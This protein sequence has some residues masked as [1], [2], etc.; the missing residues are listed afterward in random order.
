MINSTMKYGTFKLISGE[1]I[2][3]EYYVDDDNHIVLN[4]PVQIHRTITAAGPML[5]V[6]H[7]LVF[8]ESNNFK[9]KTDRIV[10]LSPKV[11]DNAL[12]HYVNFVQSRGDYVMAQ[13]SEKQEEFYSQLEE[14]MRQLQEDQVF[15]DEGPEAN[16]TIH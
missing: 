14:K 8:S 11:E 10:A 15:Q 2:I 1:E 6:S 3:S 4:N 5:S 12:A 7:W 13:T 16:T 9:I